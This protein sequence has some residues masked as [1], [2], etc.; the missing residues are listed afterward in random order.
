MLL[1]VVILLVSLILIPLFDLCLKELALT[2]AKIVL[3]LVTSLY[4]L[5]ALFIAHEFIR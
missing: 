5:W 1:V 4:V 2:I 3:L